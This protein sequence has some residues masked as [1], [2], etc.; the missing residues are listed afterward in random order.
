MAYTVLE[1]GLSDHSARLRIAPGER[2][3]LPELL[4]CGFEG[5]VENGAASLYRGCLEGI[6]K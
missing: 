5:N 4:L 1:E 2:L 3:G 6:L